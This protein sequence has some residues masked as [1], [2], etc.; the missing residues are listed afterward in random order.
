MIIDEELNEILLSVDDPELG[1]NIVD[2]GLIYSAEIK[3]EEKEIK[4]KMGVTS[5]FCP[6]SSFLQNQILD[7]LKSKFSEYSSIQVS[8][9]KDPPWN[10]SKMSDSARKRMNSK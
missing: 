3:R 7:K 2:L 6:F 8:I 5:P 4:I 10:E 9:E 1:I